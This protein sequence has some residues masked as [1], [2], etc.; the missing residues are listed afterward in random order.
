MRGCEHQIS[1]PSYVFGSAIITIVIGALAF[2]TALAWNGYVQSTFRHYSN[3][4]EALEAKLSYAFLVTAMAIVIGFI[5][6]YYIDGNK[7]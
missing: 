4:T 6:M 3:E 1:K 2:I 5:V 7:W